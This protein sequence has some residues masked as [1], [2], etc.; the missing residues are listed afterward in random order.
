M[1]SLIS[2]KIKKKKKKRISPSQL[3]QLLADHGS[4]NPDK[5]LV[6]LK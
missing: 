5:R 1:I 2:V 3:K 4:G 6:A